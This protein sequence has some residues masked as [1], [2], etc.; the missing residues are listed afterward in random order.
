MNHGSGRDSSCGMEFW[1]GSKR[2]TIQKDLFGIP[3]PEEK[4]ITLTLRGIVVPPGRDAKEQNPEVPNCHI[5]SMKN[6]K[7]VITKAHGRL[8]KRPMIITKPEYQNWKAKAVQSIES[9]LLSMCLTGS[10]ETLP[11][12]SKLFA[13]LSLLPGD[14]SV[15]D[16]PEGSW[17]VEQCEPGKEGAVILIERL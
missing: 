15:T 8:L 11:E 13:M 2:M 16:L 1:K 3:E 7:M 5:P 10:G 17:K 14:D 4:S 12:R 6:T 9:Q